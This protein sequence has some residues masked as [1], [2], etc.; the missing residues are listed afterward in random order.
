MNFLNFVQAVSC[1]GLPLGPLETYKASINHLVSLRHDCVHGS[2][3][4]F[5]STKSDRDLASA[6]F[7][8]QSMII[9]AMHVLSVELIDYFHHGRYCAP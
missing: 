9:T 3:I 8:L 1:V 2:A 6:M 5:D 7:Q 4:T